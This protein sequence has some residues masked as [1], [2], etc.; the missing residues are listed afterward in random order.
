MQTL[1]LQKQNLIAFLLSVMFA[2]VKQVTPINPK[3][4]I[5]MLAFVEVSSR[6]SQDQREISCL[7][8]WSSMK[9]KDA[10]EDAMSTI[11]VISLTLLV[12]ETDHSLRVKVN[13]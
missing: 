2:N 13:S 4:V 12:L 7:E 9:A 1:A 11:P 10:H 3:Q 8:D 5:A 6:W